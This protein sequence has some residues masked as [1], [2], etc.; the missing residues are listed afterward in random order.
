MQLVS[1]IKLS[2]YSIPRLQLILYGASLRLEVLLVACVNTHI[3]ETR[4]TS[5]LQLLFGQLGELIEVLL[6]VLSRGLSLLGVGSV[7][8]GHDLKTLRLNT[9]QRLSVVGEDT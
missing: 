2:L 9:H 7:L 6:H 3:L 4:A 8:R 1:I 5:T